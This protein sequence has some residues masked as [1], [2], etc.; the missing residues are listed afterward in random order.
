METTQYEG[1]SAPVDKPRGRPEGAKNK[2]ANPYE[3]RSNVVRQAKDVLPA[4]LDILWRKGKLRLD[5]IHKYLTIETPMNSSEELKRNWYVN[6]PLTKARI[7]AIIIEACDAREGIHWIEAGQTLTTTI[8]RVCAI[9]PKRSGWYF[10]GQLL[11]SKKIANH[12]ELNSDNVNERLKNGWC[13][14]RVVMVPAG[15]G[16]EKKRLNTRQNLAEGQESA[17]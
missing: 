12:C 10:R 2:K 3:W 9:K 11:S 15:K 16:A 13:P 8:Y 7:A 14:E 1:V 5:E 6:Q 4:V 17:D